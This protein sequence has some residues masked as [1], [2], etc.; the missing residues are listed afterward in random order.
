MADASNLPILYKNVLSGIGT[1]IGQ[2]AFLWAIEQHGED[3]MCYR[4]ETFGHEVEYLV[5]A[6]L[7]ILAAAQNGTSDE[8]CDLMMF[9]LSRHANWRFGGNKRPNYTIAA[10]RNAIGAINGKA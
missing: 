3:K 4:A 7:P 2:E 5:R 8:K 6:I 1:E 9:I 10:I